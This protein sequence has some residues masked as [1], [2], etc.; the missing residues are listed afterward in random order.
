MPEEKSEAE[1]YAVVRKHPRK[2]YT[3][4]LG[5]PVTIMQF[6]KLHRYDITVQGVDISE[7]G[8]GIISDVPIAPGFVWFWRKIGKQKGGM[9]MWSR[10][11]SGKHRAGIQFLEIPVS[12]DD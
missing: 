1:N 5:I 9:I 2:P 10:E 11:I 8:M 6:G 7:G 3:D 12:S 4:N